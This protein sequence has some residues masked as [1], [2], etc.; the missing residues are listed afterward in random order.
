[1]FWIFDTYDRTIVK[2]SSEDTLNKKF[3]FIAKILLSDP[4]IRDV[5]QDVKWRQIHTRK[6]KISSG[7]FQN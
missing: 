1:L 7:D 2:R 3:T 5:N 4:E 6:A